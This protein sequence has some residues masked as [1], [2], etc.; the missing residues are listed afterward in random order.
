[1]KPAYPV[2]LEREELAQLGE[3]TTIL[4]TVDDQ[5][6]LTVAHLLRVSR[7]AANVIMGSTQVATNCAIWGDVIRNRTADEDLLWLVEIAEREVP[8]I[9]QARN[10]FVHAVFSVIRSMVVHGDGR[11]TVR[12]SLAMARRIKGTKSRPVTDLPEGIDRAGRLSCLVA[13]IDHLMGGKQASS[14]PWLERLAPTLPPRLD[15]AAERK[16]KAKRGQRKP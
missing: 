3:L 14:S 15:T 6:V 2:P 8:P 7:S 4:G 12:A 10:D 13:H 9:S 16:A 5:M 1:M 11:P